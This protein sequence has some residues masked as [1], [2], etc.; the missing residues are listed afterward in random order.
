MNDNCDIIL[1]GDSWTYLWHDNLLPFKLAEQLDCNNSESEGLQSEFLSILLSGIGKHT[2][3]IGIPGA[4]N[5]AAIMALKRS[6]K[7]YTPKFVIYFFT[8]SIRTRTDYN[9]KEFTDLYNASTRSK[10]EVFKLLDIYN[11]RDALLLA[12]TFIETAP[13]NSHCLILGGHE[14]FDENF[15]TSI[16]SKYPEHSDRFHLVTP[17]IWQLLSEHST[18]N[19]V[20]TPPH[21]GYNFLDIIDENADEEFVDYLLSLEDIRDRRSSE[22]IFV[23]PDGA[24][25]PN[26]VGQFIVF[27]E[28]LKCL[29]NLE[30]E[31]I[32][33]K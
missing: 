24:W 21:F 32:D 3:N 15:L 33:D 10:A 29:N 28:I 18:N 20:E 4:D 27:N 5:N 13:D 26:A 1:S 25:H 30:K 12:D 9:K 11:N 6:M 14:Y 16:R 19:F 8:E 2:I 31:F 17:S 23:Q 22:S 7:T